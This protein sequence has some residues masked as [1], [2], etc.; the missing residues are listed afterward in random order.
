MA[1]WI[2][3]GEHD[4]EAAYHGA[5]GST[6]I[7]DIETAVESALSDFDEESDPHEP[8][9]NNDAYDAIGKDRKRGEQ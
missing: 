3:G 8:M 2:V 9:L 7:D 4:C 5:A 1:S 6:I